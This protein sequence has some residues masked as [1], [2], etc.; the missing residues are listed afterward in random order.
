MKNELSTFER[1]MEIVSILKNMPKISRREL[2][3]RF[4]VS[5]MSITRDIIALSKYV[6]IASTYGKNGG[7]Y[8]VNEYDPKRV[9]LSKEQTEFLKKLCCSL[10]GKEKET[11]QAIIYKF[12]LPQS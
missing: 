6:P 3:R 9:Y 10:K 5:N 1:R 2:A 11:M 4:S 12:A 7:I 8:I